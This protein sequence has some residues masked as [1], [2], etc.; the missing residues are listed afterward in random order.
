[1]NRITL[2]RRPTLREVLGYYEREDFR[3]YLAK[4]CGVRRVVLVVNA[5][6]MKL[7]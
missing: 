2:G 4:V 5:G 1:M 6:T 7:R 3:A